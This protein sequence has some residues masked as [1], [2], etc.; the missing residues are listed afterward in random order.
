MKHAHFV[1]VL[2]LS[3][4]L[5]MQAPLARASDAENETSIFETQSEASVH[6]VLVT[7]DAEG[8][9]KGYQPLSK[10]EAA[11]FS[12]NPFDMFNIYG[13][14]TLARATYGIGG[15]TALGFYVTLGV[16]ITKQAFD[17]EAGTGR[18]YENVMSGVI[19]EL[20]PGVSGGE[21]ALGYRLG[22]MIGI[23]GHA[24]GIPLPGHLAIKAALDHIWGP[25]NEHVRTGET[26]A[27]LKA[28]A[29]F[30]LFRFTV[31]VMRKLGGD[32]NPELGNLNMRSSDGKWMTTLGF[33]VFIL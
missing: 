33:Q 29:D 18:F 17:P 14:R 10:S 2:A 3:F 5:S 20:S 16:L 25:S 26:F 24:G 27:G 8:K 9:V 1:T 11:A 6:P 4:A 15:D 19:I 22:A 7:H 21:L 31:G 12:L 32:A 13:D 28:D 30:M 23:G